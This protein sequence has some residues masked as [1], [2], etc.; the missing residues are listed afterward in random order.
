MLKWEASLESLFGAWW[1]LNGSRIDFGPYTSTSSRLMME[2]S[3]FES[4]RQLYRVGVYSSL[5]GWLFFN[6][7]DRN[8]ITTLYF[9]Y[10]AVSGGKIGQ[11]TPKSS[12]CSSSS[13]STFF[14]ISIIWY[15]A[16][17]D[18]WQGH[19]LELLCQTFERRA[20]TCLCHLSYEKDTAT[21]DTQC[22]G[23][24][25]FWP[26]WLKSPPARPHRCNQCGHSS[27][28]TLDDWYYDSIA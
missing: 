9:T 19:S 2:S 18:I 4:C 23:S 8:W 20:C 22:E 5:V 1:M 3:S 25:L 7:L 28:A 26:S 16:I 6:W 27:V 12:V 13:S 14:R 21:H 24:Q 17:D 11:T 15:S 10:N